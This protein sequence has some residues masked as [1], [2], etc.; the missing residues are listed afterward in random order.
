MT[1]RV[2]LEDF[3]LGAEVAALRA[4]NPGV[5]PWP[6]SSARCAMSATARASA[7]WSSALSRHDE[8]ALE[9]IEAAARR[10]GRCSA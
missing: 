1:V 6:A 4:G 9:Q 2:Q 8:K 3:D 10:A 5:G 7:R